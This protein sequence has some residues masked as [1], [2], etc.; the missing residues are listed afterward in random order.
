M[1]VAAP[2][3]MNVTDIIPEYQAITLLNK[4]H[5]S[6]VSP[7]VQL[8]LGPLLEI[9]ESFNWTHVGSRISFGLLIGLT[10]LLL[11]IV[12]CHWGEPKKIN[13]GRPTDQFELG[14]TAMRG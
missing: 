7:H 14:Y 4:P 11:F 8:P 3:V 5:L 13:I 6:Q 2:Q 12:P 9:P 1:R 10:I